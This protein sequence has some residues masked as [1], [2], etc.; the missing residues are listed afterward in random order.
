LRAGD[1]LDAAAGRGLVLLA[2]LRPPQVCAACGEERQVA[3]R[4]RNGRP[5]CGGCRDQDPGDPLARLVELI[6]ATDPDLSADAVRSAITGTV[7]KG[8]VSHFAVV[9]V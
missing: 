3:F 9:A 1:H 6:T 5:R 7:T 2:V 8:G 4:D